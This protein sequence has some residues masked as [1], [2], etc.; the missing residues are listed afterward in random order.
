[1]NSVRKY[2]L[3]VCG[4]SFYYFI[5]ALYVYLYLNTLMCLVILF[6]T[7]FIVHKHLSLMSINLSLLPLTWPMALNY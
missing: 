3:L 7:S 4:V 2:I 6:I 5:F 1:M